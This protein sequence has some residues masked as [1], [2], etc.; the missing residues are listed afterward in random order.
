M[1]MTP[2]AVLLQANALQIPLADQSVHMVVRKDKCLKYKDNVLQLCYKSMSPVGAGNTIQGSQHNAVRTRYCAMPT[3][4]FSIAVPPCRGDVMP[5]RKVPSE[6]ILRALYTQGFSGREIARQYGLNVNTV[7][8]ALQRYGIVSRTPNETKALQK[9]RGVKANVGKYWLGKKMPPDLVEKRASKIRG[10]RHW[11]W[12]GGI[13][14]ARKANAKPA[15]SLGRPPSGQ[16]TKGAH[17]RTPQPFWEKHWLLTEYVLKQR[18]AGE[19]AAEFGC[20]ERNILYF[21]KKHAIP[22]RSVSETRAVK[23]WGAPGE[24]NPM[25]GRRGKEVPNWKGGKTPERQ[26]FYSS[27]EWKTVAKAVWKRDR[28]TCQ[29]CH[30]YALGRGGKDFHIH[31]IVSFAYAPLRLEPTNLVLVCNTCHRWIHSRRNSDQQ[32][33]STIPTQEEP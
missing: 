25:F 23:H 30:K 26:G 10:E 7:I 29:R 13:E 16:F 31:H 19:I 24:S 8:A 32:W 6:D 28:G 2:K 14:S 5:T 21:L 9:A 11:M 15:E 17:W 1:P 20:D 27:I 22:T 33:L 4:D 3:Y 12:K 18:S